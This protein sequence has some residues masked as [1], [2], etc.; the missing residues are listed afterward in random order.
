LAL[1][2][3]F[4]LSTIYVK[5]RDIGPIWEVCL[6]AG[7][8]MTPIIY[9]ITFVSDRHPEIAKIMLLNPIAQIIQDARYLL[10]SSQ[11]MTVWQMFNNKIY[12]II[13]YCIPVIVLAIGLLVFN[14]NAKKFAEIL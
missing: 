14:K 10:T 1:G 5:Y 9:P 12:A 6:Q 8:Y 7:M 3:S 13:P 4:I 11:N 2:V